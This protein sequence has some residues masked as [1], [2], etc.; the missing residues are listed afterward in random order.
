MKA[1]VFFLT[2]LFAG[3]VSAQTEEFTYC[4]GNSS[5]ILIEKINEE[6]NND[7]VI[8]TYRQ[9]GG[10]TFQYHI[11][12]DS[13]FSKHEGNYYLI[14][15]NHAQIGDIW[16][17]LWYGYFKYDVDTSQY[18]PCALQRNLK[19]VGIEQI[20]VGSEY[21]LKYKLLVL[22]SL[23]TQ[24]IDEYNPTPVYFYFIEGVGAFSAGLYYNLAWEGMCKITMTDMITPTFKMYETD[25]NKYIENNC[26][27]TSATNTN[28]L[29]NV[30][31]KV[32]NNYLYIQ[33][34]ENENFE[35]SF[36]D[37]TGK[38]ILKTT[39]QQ[40]IDIS[41]LKGLTIIQLH[42]ENSYKIVKFNFM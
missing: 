41:T 42:T 8:K 1:K 29:V 39:N 40:Q 18:N 19:V 24:Y 21:R 30:N 20:T 9:S 5:I 26:Q 38:V 11:F 27:T 33:G 28:E 7:T 25:N 12:N 13:I 23:F 6:H 15:A 2:L 36:V 4:V 32:E 37:L 17:P 35:V 34:V 22:D 16:Q 3:I 14:G 10:Q 31:F